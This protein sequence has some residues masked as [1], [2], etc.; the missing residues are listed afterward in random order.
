M[1]WQGQMFGQPFLPLYLPCSPLISAMTLV[2]LFTPFQANGE[3]GRFRQTGSW[4]KPPVYTGKSWRKVL[5]RK[6]VVVG[7]TPCPGGCGGTDAYS[8]NME[9]MPASDEGIVEVSASFRQE[10]RW[11]TRKAPWKSWR[12]LPR[13]SQTWHPTVCFHRKRIFRQPARHLKSD[14]G[15]VH[16]GC[17]RK[18]E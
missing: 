13:Q 16:R 9:L 3:E 11:R 15:A 8:G 6:L 5:H 12:R 10:P 1:I 14:R 18:V 17:D 7:V 2:P 4:I